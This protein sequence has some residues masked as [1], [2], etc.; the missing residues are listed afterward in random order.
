MDLRGKFWNRQVLVILPTFT[1]SLVVKG[2]KAAM[3][4]EAKS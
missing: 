4:S 1:F 2:W 3:T